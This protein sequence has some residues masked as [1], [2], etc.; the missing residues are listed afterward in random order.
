MEKVVSK[1]YSEDREG[2]L[3]E[4]FLNLNF[5]G[6]LPPLHFSIFLGFQCVTVWAFFIKW[7][8]V[9]CCILITYGI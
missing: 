6:F 8:C 1:R 3:E 9:N 2:S 4:F 7:G 5:W